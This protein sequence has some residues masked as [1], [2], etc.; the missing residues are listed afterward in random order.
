MEEYIFRV[1][2]AIESKV[3]H[4]VVAD[5][6]VACIIVVDEEVVQPF[7][8]VVEVVQELIDSTKDSSMVLYLSLHD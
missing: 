2:V 1:V 5:K 3:S 7:D 6:E 8:V 4:I